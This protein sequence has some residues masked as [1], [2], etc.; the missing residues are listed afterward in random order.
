MKKKTIDG[1]T[2]RA[3]ERGDARGRDCGAD[4]SFVTKD[5]DADILAYTRP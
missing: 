1:A 5:D 3:R 2:A 4:E